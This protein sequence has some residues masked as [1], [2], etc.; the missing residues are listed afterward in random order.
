MPGVD[1][2]I[3]DPGPRGERGTRGERGPAGEPGLEGPQGPEGPAGEP[4]TVRTVVRYGLVATVGPRPFASFAAC[5]K[6]E[7][8]TGGGFD[9][10]RSRELT[11]FQVRADRASNSETITDEEL[12]ER[13][14][15]EELG[16]EGEVFGQDEF[17]NFFVYRD[18]KD[19]GAATG[20][21]VSLT[22][23]GKEPETRLQYRAYVVCATSVRLIG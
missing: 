6:G 21:A 15:R 2:A 1:G 17:G 7:S 22:T 13:E 11:E 14:E 12:K 4:G 5:R 9:L 10:L 23:T 18:P 20:W 8:I 16:E 3:G 19:G